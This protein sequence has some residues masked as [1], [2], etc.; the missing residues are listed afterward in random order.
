MSRQ[1]IEEFPVERCV[2]I[3]FETFNQYLGEGTILQVLCLVFVAAKGLSDTFPSTPS[4]TQLFAFVKAFCAKNKGPPLVKLAASQCSAARC[5]CSRLALSLSSISKCLTSIW[6][7]DAQTLRLRGW[8]VPVTYN[9]RAVL[10]D[11]RVEI[12][13]KCKL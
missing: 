8:T 5:V 1:A 12:R 11:M 10:E 9:S 2:E 13:S 6:S 3:E 4:Q 7:W